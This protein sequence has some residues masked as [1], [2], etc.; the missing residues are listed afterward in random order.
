MRLRCATV[1]SALLS[2]SPPTP[3]LTAQQPVRVLRHAPADTARPGDVITISF[4]RPV[5]GS[6]ERTP[7]LSRVVRIEPALDVR[8]QWR[9]P[10]TLRIVPR[11]PLTPGRSYRITIANDFAAMDG[12]RL[13]APYVFTITTRGPAILASIPTLTPQYAQTIE[14]NG[15]IRLIYSAP[16][17]S[18]AL[19]GVARLEIARS[20]ECVARSIRY[21]VHSQRPITDADDW[22]IRYAGGYDRDSLE[23]QFRRLVEIRPVARLPE[24]CS[25]TIVLPSLD[26]TDRAEIR[27]PVHTQPRF[28][29][30]ALRC[31]RQDCAAGNDLHF[32][33]TAPV[34]RESL[35]AHLHVEPRVPFTLGP[36]GVASHEWKIELH[37]RPRTTY[38]VRVDS[39]L[40][41][42]YG[43]RITG[44]RTAAL[45][46][47]D[48]LPTLGH[49]LGF[50]AVSRARPVIRLTHVNVDRAIMAIVPIPDSLRLLI[51]GLANDQDSVARTVARLGDSIVRRIQLRAEHNVEHISDIPI[52]TTS[53]GGRG[54]PTPT[55]LL[56]IR[57]RPFSRAKADTIGRLSDGTV[58]IGSADGNGMVPS[59][60]V[61]IVQ[62]T[63]LVAHAKVSDVWGSVFVTDANTG[64]PVHGARVTTRDSADRIMASGETDTSGVAR[65]EPVAGRVRPPRER[66]TSGWRYT[67]GNAALEARVVEVV[68]GADRS[69]V[70]LTNEYW[71]RLDAVYRLGGQLDRTRLA[72]ATAFTDR[73]IYRPGEMVYVTSILRLGAQASLRVPARGDSVRVIVKRQEPGD[74]TERVIR[75]TVLRLGTYGTAA[76]SFRLGAATPLGSYQVHVEA[77]DVGW[78]TAGTSWFSVAEYRTPEFET[79]VAID[80]GIKFR[81]DVVQAHA[82]SRYY[83]G[84]PMRGAVVRWSAMTSEARGGVPVPG[85][86]SGYAIGRQYAGGTESYPPS[87]NTTGVDTLDADGKA[88]IRIATSSAPSASPSY[89]SVSVAVADVNRQV[90]GGSHSTVLHSSSFYIAAHDSGIGSWYWKENVPRSVSLLTVRPDGRRVADARVAVTVLRHHMKLE[91]YDDGRSPTTTWATDTVLRDSLRTRDRP[92]PYTYTPRSSGWH[93]LIFT[94][95]DER[96]PPSDVIIGRSRSSATSLVASGRR[97]A[98]TRFAS[99]CR[100]TTH[101]WRSGTPSPSASSRHSRARKRG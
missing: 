35:L 32:Y 55:P 57:I 76:D 52:P 10:T 67:Y 89:L 44:G 81:G 56:A 33:L 64:R 27:Y 71:S 8:T 48:R 40:R 22:S 1:V 65:L 28:T 26:P 66:A 18:A 14:P 83:F 62:V 12:G 59:R 74:G 99:P 68:H 6:L 24:Q 98:T 96:D 50:F 2:L 63:D 29:V 94:S 87:M 20:P 77:F 38:R 51:L 21:A 13:D 4:D 79:K 60:R 5:A 7:D 45:N 36:S 69:F 46:V 88:T 19:S 53:L 47:G 17:D 75:D 91:L 84:A 86:P 90:I 58:V 15:N 80:S 34:Q 16:V 30:E 70:P 82:S 73:A 101:P 9:D 54:T 37:V 100:W 92:T 42:I 31:E 93:E 95:V 78:Q 3:T 72:H 41:D 39:S 61:A 85:L 97:G 49:E 43:R 25:A 23:Q 11:E